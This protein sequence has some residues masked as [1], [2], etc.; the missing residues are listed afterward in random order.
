[1]LNADAKHYS[2]H[3]LKSERAHLFR[4]FCMKFIVGNGE[5]LRRRLQDFPT[6]WVGDFVAAKILVIAVENDESLAAYGVRSMLNVASLYVKEEYR[7]QGI[8]KQIRKIA[9]NEAQKR[10]IHFLT[11]E[12]SFRLLSSKYG[13]VLSSKFRCRVIKRLKKRKS[14]LVV[15]PLTIKGHLVY[16]FLRM[17]FS[18]VPGELLEPISGWI[19]RR[20]LAQK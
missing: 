1:M 4:G 15:F 17:A 16:V 12:V 11:G 8:G 9:F 20:S 6:A 7:R 3:Q 19:G 13:L 18:I 5:Q 10:G 14:A 2:S